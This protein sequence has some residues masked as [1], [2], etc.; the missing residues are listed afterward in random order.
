L[1]YEY[2]RS[3]NHTL[4]VV[5][6]DRTL[7]NLLDTVY[8]LGDNKITVY[9]GNYEFY[10]SQKLIENEALERDLKSKEK[11]LRKARDVERDSLERQQKLDARGKRKQEKAGQPTIMMN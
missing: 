7:L 8:E 11:A 3:T 10:T 2:I 6:H 4:L 9:G 5:S 1:L